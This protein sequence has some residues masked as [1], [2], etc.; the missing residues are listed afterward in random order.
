VRYGRTLAQVRDDRAELDHFAEADGV[1]L[2]ELELL[3]RAVQGFERVL[4][5][6]ALA[7]REEPCAVLAAD[8]LELERAQMQDR[9]T[10]RNRRVLDTEIAVAGAADHDLSAPGQPE[11]AAI[12][13]L[14]DDEFEF[15]RL[16]DF[17]ST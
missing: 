5:V 11:T 10:T 15:G 13:T 1:A 17:G 14:V 2:T 7:P 16:V 3:A 6:L 12:L 8:V 9:M 4:V